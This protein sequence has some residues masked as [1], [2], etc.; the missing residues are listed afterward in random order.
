MAAETFAGISILSRVSMVFV[1]LLVWVIVFGLL[2]KVKPMGPEKKN[3][4]A[5]I[6]LC[7]A[8][9]VVISGAAG[10]MIRFMATWFFVMVLFVFL[11]IFTIGTLG[12][13]EKKFAAAGSQGAVYFWIIT[14]GVI[15]ALF[16]FGQAFGQGLLS[17]RSGQTTNTEA[18]TVEYDA[19]GQPLPPVATTS[20]GGDFSQNVLTTMTHPKIL[21]FVLLMLIGVVAVWF[22]TRSGL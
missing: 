11:I 15:I 13:D 8:F 19:N 10:F 22:L 4:H 2:E 14:F 12:V 9:F 3:L 5:L 20:G 18:Q 7:M 16:A 6:A 1:W 17:M 21:G